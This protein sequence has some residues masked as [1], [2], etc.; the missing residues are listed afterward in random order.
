M[1]ARARRR[2]RTHARASLVHRAYFFINASA[3]ARRSPAD[4]ISS[5]RPS[6]RSFVRSRLPSSRSS[7]IAS[8]PPRVEITSHDRRARAS[9]TRARARRDDKRRPTD[10]PTT[11]DRPTRGKCQMSEYTYL[12][13]TL[14]TTKYPYRIHTSHMGIYTLHYGPRTHRARTRALEP[15]GFDKPLDRIDRRHTHAR[16][17]ASTSFARFATHS[18][19]V[20][21]RRA[22]RRHARGSFG[23]T[24][25]EAET[26]GSAIGPDSTEVRMICACIAHEW[27]E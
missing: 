18:R 17:M 24:R 4:A 21:R 25:A 22:P 1:D 5:V 9:G 27:N 15:K 26:A 19:A 3:R 20:D 2:Q 13:C 14:K 23:A 11:D 7:P 10:R 6:V 8:A 16:A 12:Y